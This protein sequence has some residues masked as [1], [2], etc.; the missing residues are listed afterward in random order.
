MNVSKPKIGLF[1]L[2]SCEGCLVQVLNL[3]DH[4]LDMFD[5]IDVPIFRLLKEERV[6]VPLDIAIVEGCVT[7]P[8]EET[9]INR[10]RESSKILV[11]LGECASYGGVFM[12]RDF[13]RVEAKVPPM[14]IPFEARAIDHYVKVDH[15]V[16]GCPID[17]R[18]FLRTFKAL[19]QGKLIRPISYNIC[20]ECV[21]RE[22][23]CFLDK[24]KLCLG[25]ITCGGDGALCPS[26]GKECTGCRGFAEDS[27]VEAFIDICRERGIPVPEVAIHLQELVKAGKGKRK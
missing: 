12:M 14:D 26:Q 5:R 27:N 20:A 13:E 1:S 8:D 4:L 2:T 18:D 9:K 16:H 22:N 23:E 21:L 17:R 7:R 10:I 3:E 15:Y 11:A 24:G 25:P 6:E 19:L